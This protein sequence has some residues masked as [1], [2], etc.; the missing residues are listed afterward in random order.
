MSQYENVKSLWVLLQHKMHWWQVELLRRVHH[1]HEAIVR[2]TSSLS[3]S[4][5]FLR[6]GCP[7]CHSTNSAKELK[8]AF[9]IKNTTLILQQHPV[10]AA[11]DVIHMISAERTSIE[12]N[13][14]FI[15]VKIHPWKLRGWTVT[16]RRKT[17]LHARTSTN[18]HKL[19]HISFIINTTN[20]TVTGRARTIPPQMIP[21]T[22]I[23]GAQHRYPKWHQNKA[24]VWHTDTEDRSK[25][26]YI[27]L[28][29]STY[30]R[31]V[32]QF[33]T[34]DISLCLSPMTTSNMD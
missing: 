10:P 24:I 29:E 2:F 18:S 6:T 33:H 20:W 3:S 4:L 23:P 5:S 30:L 19:T 1:Q 15:T 13:E 8:A 7:P 34:P 31:Y 14:L 25:P 27:S 26:I 16:C 21:N 11:C 17:N 9:Y 12:N 32:C 22:T 28:F